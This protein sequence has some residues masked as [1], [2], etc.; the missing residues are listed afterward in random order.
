MVVTADH[1]E[2]FGE[3]GVIEHGSSVYDDQVRVPL[4][5]FPPAGERITAGPDPVSLIDLATTLAQIGG[6]EPLGHGRDLRQVGLPAPVPIE[7]FG[8]WT[9]RALRG[10]RSD[11]PAS[12]VVVD[13]WKLIRRADG[14]ELYDLARDRPE[15]DDLSA[16]RLDEVDALAAV[17]PELPSRDGAV[18]GSAREGLTP[19]QQ[20]ILR[21]L[22]YL[23]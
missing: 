17:M 6:S 15:I 18:P 19:E 21:S 5:I 12:A 7:F 13:R 11:E 10:P 23:D 2:S 3:H 20:E 14:V 16:I 1:G 22:G 9:G 8:N 4:V